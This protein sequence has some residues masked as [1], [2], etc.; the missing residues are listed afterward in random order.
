[1]FVLPA[2]WCVQELQRLDN[3]KKAAVA[4]GE[5]LAKDVQRNRMEQEEIAIQIDAVKRFLAL[6]DST[7]ASS[8]DPSTARTQKPPP[9]ANAGAAADG[10]SEVARLPPP[11]VPPP[12]T[13]QTPPPPA[14]RASPPMPTAYVRA[15]SPAIPEP[16]EKS[17]SGSSS[18]SALRPRSE[19]SA[20]GRG[21][22]SAR[23]RV[24]GSRSSF[25]LAGASITVGDKT[26][27]DPAGIVPGAGLGSGAG[28]AVEAVSKG[29]KK[30]SGRLAGRCRKPRGNSSSSSD[31]DDDGASGVPGGVGGN[32]NISSLY[33]YIMSMPPSGGG[34]GARAGAL[35][36]P[37]WSASKPQACEADV[38]VFP[39]RVLSDGTK[40]G[41]RSGSGGGGNGGP[42]RGKEANIGSFHILKQLMFRTTR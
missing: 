40:D 5:A 14:P 23:G 29:A 42:M 24:P 33:G 12:G 37:G 36:I 35:A 2:A 11:S 38:E 10:D 34:T 7:F 31:D 13:L 39:N 20:R 32:G 21:G 1:M 15:P 9:S 19:P 25:V 28:A 41:A 3:R 6:Y 8:E 22:S 26:P 18:P 27:N 17:P 4:V 30:G 16:L